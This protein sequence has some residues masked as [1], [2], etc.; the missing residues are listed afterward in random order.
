MTIALA[1]FVLVA[2]Y[3]AGA[4]PTGLLLGRWTAG[5]DL[6]EHGSKNIGFTNAIRVLGWKRG[7]PVLPIDVGKA[8]VATTVLPL[9]PGE[10]PFPHFSIAVGI[11]VMTGN[12]VNVFLRF[13]GGKGVATGAGVFLA[14]CPLP[15]L[16]ALA[17]FGVVLGT[18]RYMSLA[19]MT[20]VLLLA[21]AAFLQ[22]GASAIF[23]VTALTAVTI[24]VKHRA[25][26][27]R[28]VSGTENKV[29]GGK[30]G[31]APAAN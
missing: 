31:A 11:A 8:F 7:W 26:I 2:A 5:V 3:F 17:G 16:V 19:S 12:M 22:T 27:G 21:V 28:L 4:L 14:L 1:V 25:N 20:A 9:I 13:R 10:A 18:T 23:V 6:R 15:L 29:G 24:L 30:S